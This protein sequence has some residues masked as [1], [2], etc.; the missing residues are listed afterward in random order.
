MAHPHDIPENLGVL[1]YL[2]QGTPPAEVVVERPPA[3]VDIRRLGA[4]PDIVEWLW[5]R[6]GP[7][8]PVDARY[9]IAGGAALVDPD[10]GLI[11]AVA[12]GTQYAIRVG[13]TESAA[14]RDAGYETTHTFR[15]VGR[16]LD[17]AESFGP[18]WFFG[19]FDQREVDWLR[20][21]RG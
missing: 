6:V 4:H 12:I 15:S 13:D 10:S 14:A 16:T 3:D 8:L 1:R 7:S 2:G 20:V 11:L 19:Q 5:W 9:L 21:A 18:G 17:L